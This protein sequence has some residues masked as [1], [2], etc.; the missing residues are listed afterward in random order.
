METTRIQIKTQRQS[1]T[2]THTRTHTWTHTWTHTDAV[3]RQRAEVS[4]E[5]SICSQRRTMKTTLALNK[6]VMKA[7]PPN[8]NHDQNNSLDQPLSKAAGLTDMWTD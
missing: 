2:H 8:A 7:I 3:K 4:G 1:L 5:I 6:Q